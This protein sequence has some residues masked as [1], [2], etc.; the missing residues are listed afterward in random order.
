MSRTTRTVIFLVAGVAFGGLLI[1]GF[2]GLPDF[3]HYRGPYGIV[4]QHV[5]VHQRHA[6]DIVTATTFDYRGFD[7]LGEEFIL[8]TAV[9]GLVVLLR[10][11]RGEQEEEEEETDNRQ[12]EKGSP[13]LRVLGFGLA[14]LVVVLGIY[15]VT[16]GH[17]TPGGGFQGGTILA[18]AFVLA[19]L[20]GHY[21]SFGDD[22]Q[23]SL[24]ELADA[25]GA[26]GFVL[27]G[28]GGLVA[29]FQF[30]YNFLPL[31]TASQLLS[32]GMIPLLNVSVG[33]E[34][35]GAFALLFAEFL[36][37]RLTEGRGGR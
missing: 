9:M 19:Y 28:L 3:G 32:A 26:A 6:T 22:R 17:L 30:L 15:I 11:Q 21:L 23:M 35:T 29:G 16:H 14:G 33:L 2:L 25:C 34:V 12:E 31:G 8:F 7:T 36:G 13:A 20:A 37:Q 5:A 4:L 1:W 18:A 27:V 24:I 10:R